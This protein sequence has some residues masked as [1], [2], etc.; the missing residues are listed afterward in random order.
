[1]SFLDEVDS[2]KAKLGIGSI[3]PI[4]LLGVAFAVLAA[5]IAIAVLAWGGFTEPGV[6]VE[7]GENVE[8]CLLY[9]SDAAD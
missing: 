9:T 5:V 2:L 6:V 1:M 8:S 7:H 4:A 3:N